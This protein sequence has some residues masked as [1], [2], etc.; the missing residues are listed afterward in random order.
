MKFFRHVRYTKFRTFLNYIVIAFLQIIKLFQLLRIILPNNSQKIQE[1]SFLVKLTPPELSKVSVEQ[2]WGRASHLF[3]DFQFQR[4]PQRFNELC[5]GSGHWIGKILTVVDGKMIEREVRK[6]G[7]SPS[8]QIGIGSP[9]V[10]DYCSA[11][12]T[13]RRIMAFKVLRSRRATG[14]IRT[15]TFPF[16]RLQARPKHQGPKRA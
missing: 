5:V 14:N 6:M 8:G 7:W 4:T 10:T 15:S 12:L 3:Q 11:P 13:T 2:I 1:W 9:F 16:G